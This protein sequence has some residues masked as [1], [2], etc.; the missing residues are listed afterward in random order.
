[1]KADEQVREQREREIEAEA[2]RIFEKEEA[3]L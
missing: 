3:K 2:K 1:L